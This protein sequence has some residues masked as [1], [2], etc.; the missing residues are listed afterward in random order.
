MTPLLPLLP[1]LSPTLAAALASAPPQDVETLERKIVKGDTCEAIARE[2]YGDSKHVDV[3]HRY[4]PWLGAQLPHHLEPGQAL[5]LPKTLPPPQ[6]D[7]EV[8]AARRTVEA[9]PPEA[10]DWSS[11]QPGL[12]LWRGWRVNTRDDASAEITFRDQSRIQLRENTLVIIYGGSGTTKARRD[13]AEATL[14]RGALRSRLGAYSGKAAPSVT[15]T[16]PSAV[17]EFVGGQSLVTVDDGGTSRVANHGEGKAAVRSSGARGPKVRVAPKMGSKVDKG[18]VPTKPKPLPPTPAWMERDPTTFVAAGEHGG[19]ITGEWGA[20]A[21]AASYRVEISEDP[22]G[23]SPIATQIVPARIHRFE[24]KGLPNGH[25]YARVAAID[26]DA[27]ESPPSERRSLV[28]VTAGLLTPGAAP[29]PPSAEPEASASLRVLRGT[30]VLAPAGLRCRVDD[31][32][33]SSEPV[34]TAAGEHVVSCVTQDGAPARGFAVIVSETK[35]AATSTTHAA[36][37]GQ[38]STFAFSLDAE[39]PA[40]RRLWVEAPEGLTVAVPVATGTPGQWQAR[41]HADPSAP[42]EATL[43]VMADA[44]GEPVELGEVALRVEDPPAPP[45]AAPSEQAPARREL[46]MVEGG[47]YG[48]VLLPSAHHN[49]FPVSRDPAATPMDDAWEPLRV[50]APSFGLRLGYYPIRFVG[51]ELEQ[52]FAPTRGRTTDERVN[53]FTVRAHVL[54]QMP[55]R[56]TP[57]VHFGAGAL[58]ITRSSV[59]GGEIDTAIYFGAGAKLFITRWAAVRL[60]VRD[61]MTEARGDGLAHSPEIVLGASMVLGRR[62]AG[63]PPRPARKR[64]R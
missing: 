8:T 13:T 51:A 22:E 12:D 52:G 30:R 56:L 16:T 60:D 58:G 33:P 10:V 32:E 64:K 19:T 5:V 54:G 20:I 57:T 24:A 9:R 49:L 34:L 47:L 40:P 59:L 1:L 26:G 6:P 48:G 4:N 50:A 46:H 63:A 21:S 38:S 14:D 3:I 44:G 2:L 17:A 28:V 53:V 37:R 35:V 15:V 36:V 23:L 25:Y 31:G 7:A 61:V 41:V 55:W 42:A 11:A 29:L 45:A 18:K 27:F 39:A 62:S 43:R